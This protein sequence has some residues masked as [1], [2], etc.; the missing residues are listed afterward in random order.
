MNLEN[1][2]PIL[3]KLRLDLR[4]KEEFRE[5]GIECLKIKQIRNTD[6][7]SFILEGLDREQ[8]TNLE[9]SSQTNP[10]DK[11]PGKQGDDGDD[12]EADLK[13][14]KS[15]DFEDKMDRVMATG[16]SLSAVSKTDQ[17][18]SLELVEEGD[19]IRYFILT[20]KPQKVYKFELTFTPQNTKPYEFRLPL[21]L[22]SSSDFN[23]ELQKMVFVEPV[24]PKIILEPIDGLRDFGK[25]IITHTEHDV[26]DRL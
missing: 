13:R 26:P 24:P 20:L 19:N 3:A 18:E 25:K 15:L 8:I 23:P 6:E 10:T 12:D 21:T 1:T 14:E 16:R 5:S 22:G 11:K 17:N 2:S 4:Q 9:K 7:E